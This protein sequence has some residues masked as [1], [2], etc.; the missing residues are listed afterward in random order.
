MQDIFVLDP[1]KWEFSELSKLA[2]KHGGPEKLLAIVKEFS[3]Q[4]GVKR[5]K[6]KMIPWLFA[7]FGVGVLARDAAPKTAQFIEHCRIKF[8]KQ[9]ITAEVAEELL[10]QLIKEDE[11]VNAKKSALNLEETM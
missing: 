6:I 7:T 4:E 5:G 8:N 10:I 2:A 3:L 9:N 1:L 11:I